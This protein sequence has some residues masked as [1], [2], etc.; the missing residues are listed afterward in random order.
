MT[1]LPCSECEGEGCWWC[2]NT[3]VEEVED[4]SDKLDEKE[5]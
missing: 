1:Q 3:G 5:A 4:I 2:N